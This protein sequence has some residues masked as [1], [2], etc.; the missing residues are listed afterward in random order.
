M[1]FSTFSLRNVSK[2]IILIMN[3]MESFK[4]SASTTST[5]QIN[6]ESFFKMFRKSSLHTKKNNDN[7][8][9]IRSRKKLRRKSKPKDNNS[10]VKITKLSVSIPKRTLFIMIKQR[11]KS[12]KNFSKTSIFL[13]LILK[14]SLKRN[15]S[16]HKNKNK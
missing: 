15:P 12:P 3:S 11:V 9:I 2:D 6:P 1:K 8:S 7:S 14:T 16:T 10:T 5:T 13:T 4:C